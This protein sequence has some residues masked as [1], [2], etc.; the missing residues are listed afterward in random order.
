MAVDYENL[1]DILPLVG[2]ALAKLALVMLRFLNMDESAW[3]SFKNGGAF[4]L[5]FERVFVT[6]MFGSLYLTKS[7]APLPRL[8]FHSSQPNDLFLRFGHP[9]FSKIFGP[10][11]TF[12][13]FPTNSHVFAMR[14]F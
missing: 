10:C 6:D 9:D 7:R 8:N 11:T 4:L 13:L 14:I 5:I 2:T 3:F 1:I 12:L